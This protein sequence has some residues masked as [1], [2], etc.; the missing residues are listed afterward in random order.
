MVEESASERSHLFTAVKQ[1]LSG[2]HFEDDRQVQL[3]QDG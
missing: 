2:H 3:R 1:Y